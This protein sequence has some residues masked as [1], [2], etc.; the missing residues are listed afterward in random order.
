M[1]DDIEVLETLKEKAHGIY[2]E[3]VL[4]ALTSQTEVGIF[5]MKQLMKKEVLDSRKRSTKI[6]RANQVTKK[7]SKMKRK[8]KVEC[9]V[10]YRKDPDLRKEMIHFKQLHILRLAIQKARNILLLHV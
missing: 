6:S 1:I 2:L 4:S 3:L 10:Y 7:Y 5:V 9:P 8:T